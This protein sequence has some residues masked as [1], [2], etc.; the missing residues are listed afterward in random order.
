M[1]EVRYFFPIRMMIIII[2]I[3]I[4]F[5]F[6]LEWCCITACPTHNCKTKVQ[7]CHYIWSWSYHLL[8]MFLRRDSCLV[9]TCKCTLHL[10]DHAQRWSFTEISCFGITESSG[11]NPASK[12]CSVSDQRI[13]TTSEYLG[14]FALSQYFIYR[15]N[16]KHQKI[17]YLLLFIST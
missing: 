12:V 1:C 8:P 13:A 2:M 17:I 6:S 5:R 14:V 3:E 4:F 7:C 15:Y 9:W 10:P 16:T 11:E